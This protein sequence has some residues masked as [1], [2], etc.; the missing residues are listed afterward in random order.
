M[1]A[2]GQEKNEKNKKY[3]LQRGSA[4]YRPFLEIRPQGIS[5]Q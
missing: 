2:H 1:A 3:F 4:L 5:R